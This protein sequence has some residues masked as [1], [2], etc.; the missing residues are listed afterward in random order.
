MATS[1]LTSISSVSPVSSVSSVSSVSTPPTTPE[2]IVSS[3]ESEV[4]IIKRKK[5]KKT[6][7]KSKKKSKVKSPDIASIDVSQLRSVYPELKKLITP[8]YWVLPNQ[9]LFLDWLN[10][11][12]TYDEERDDTYCTCTN[13]LC[14][15]VGLF[16]QQKIVRD[17]FQLLSPYRGILLYHGLGVG[18][19]CASIAIAEG[20][21][22]QR[23]VLFLSK[24]SLEQNFK[25]ELKFCGND[26]FIKHRNHWIFVPCESEDVKCIQL[27]K[28]KGIH[29]SIIK[30]NKGLWLID[31]SKKSDNFSSL[32]SQQQ[33]QIERQIDD[34][35]QIKY[36][37]MHYDAS[38][39]GKKLEKTSSNPF[40]NKLLIIDEVHNLINSIVNR[41]SIGRVLENKIMN[42]KN[43][44]IVALS[45]TPIVNDIFEIGK[46]FNIL[47]GFIDTFIYRYTNRISDFKKIRDQLMKEPTIDYIFLDQKNNR[48]VVTKNPTGFINTTDN[49]GIIRTDKLVTNEDFSSSIQEILKKNGVQVVEIEIKQNTALPEEKDIFYHYFYDKKNNILRNK[50]LFATRM[51]GL[52]SYYR[53]AGDELMPTSK[54]EL[55]KIPMSE[56]QF[57]EYVKIRSKELDRERGKM[58]KY[59]SK[60]ITRL[61]VTSVSEPIIDQNIFK[62]TDTYKV[63]SRMACAFVF[64]QEISRPN[65]KM[66]QIMTDFEEFAIHNYR[67]WKKRVDTDSSEVIAEAIFPRFKKDNKKTYEGLPLYVQDYFINK[68]GSMIEYAVTMARYKEKKLETLKDDKDRQE[69]E[70]QFEVQFEVK[71]SNNS[72]RKQITYYDEIKQSALVKLTETNNYLYTH[73]HVLSPK[74]KSLLEHVQISPGTIFIYSEYRNLEGL[75]ILSKILDMNG[76]VEFKITK[77]KQKQWD[78]DI[79][80][81]YLDSPKYIRWGGQRNRDDVL[82]KIFNNQLHNLPPMTKKL[83]DFLLGKENIRGDIVK[84]LMT[85]KTGAEGITL[86]NVRQVHILEPYWNYG[87][88]EQV[89][90]RAIRAC[91]HEE[92]PEED[93][94]VVLYTYITTFTPEQKIH[95]SVSRDDGFTTDEYL[96]ELSRKKK[97]ITDELFHLMKEAAFD[98][99]LHHKVNNV[100]DKN[101]LVCVRHLDYYKDGYLYRPNITLDLREEGRIARK[102][103][104]KTK[105]KTKLKTLKLKKY[106][107]PFI[108]DTANGGLYTTKKSQGKLVKDMKVGEF[109]MDDGGKVTSI[110]YYKDKKV[111]KTLRALRK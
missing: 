86:K 29:Q 103:V 14:H 24:A 79:N 102:T 5:K 68:L 22:D 104:K 34:L 73:L 19:T 97:K 66:V 107:H 71:M 100:D 88:L 69:K 108:I 51:N 47:R 63:F 39:L 6:K 80:E 54:E 72:R 62:L 90:G 8:S 83:K 99:R 31:M 111:V 30:K 37:F 77:T 11:T 106:K 55:I 52:V 67:K 53:T 96:Y 95:E 94:N 84:I 59:V 15:A 91:S 105:R 61:G 64:P 78:L 33:K 42:A 101:P 27:A 20:M 36:N 70:K 7:K 48:I 57:G 40:N 17:F 35:I 38:N 60:K 9:L 56:Y 76:Y 26:Y 23:E 3:P 16:P 13:E 93:R 75:A 10:K 32:T 2:E 92:L 45:G 46:L 1:G 98:C 74:Y 50:D 28:E 43:L 58:K 89:K 65:K 49:K 12:F 87:R 4:I 18:K 109:T 82:L 25:N 44:R 81:R 41:G 110:S 21:A 85:T